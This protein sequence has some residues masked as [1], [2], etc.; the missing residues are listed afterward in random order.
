MSD[1][2]ATALDRV[3]EAD[4]RLLSPIA[5]YSTFETGDTQSI[6]LFRELD[7]LLRLENH[8]GL[9]LRSDPKAH[10]T[11]RSLLKKATE[12]FR[13][14]MPEFTPDGEGGIDIEWESQGRYLAANFSAAGGGDFLSWRERG[15]N[16]RYE[17][18]PITEEGFIKKLDW[19]MN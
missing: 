14:P 8:N 2:T 5:A 4:Y 18:E 7:A 19:L 3:R 16:G 17:G 12:L 10:R 1:G 9:S 6:E 13:V 11:A 15:P